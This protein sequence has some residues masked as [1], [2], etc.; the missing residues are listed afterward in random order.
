[1]A[2][3]SGADILCQAASVT[4]GVVDQWGLVAVGLMAVRRG[5][6]NPKMWTDAAIKVNLQ[7]PS[8]RSFSAWLEEKRGF[9]EGGKNFKMESFSND[10]YPLLPALWHAMLP[11]EKR[12]VMAIVELNGGYTTNCLHELFFEAHVLYADMQKLRLCVSAALENPH[13]LD[14]GVPA[15]DPGGN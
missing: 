8:R 4:N 12:L 15:D 5:N 13:H 7:P 9:L 6:A 11:V 10:V 1:M 2:L 14:L 3:R